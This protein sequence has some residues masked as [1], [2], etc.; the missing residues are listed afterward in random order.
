MCSAISKRHRHFLPAS[1][2]L[3][4]IISA[5]NCFAQPEQNQRLQ[6]DGARAAI[7]FRL[8]DHP[9]ARSVA[10]AGTFNKWNVTPLTRKGADWSVSIAL[11]PGKHLYKFV[12]GSGSDHP[13]VQRS[14]RMNQCDGLVISNICLFG[15]SLPLSVLIQL[16][17]FCTKLQSNND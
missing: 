11:P 14:N 16:K 9:R 6:T 15:R 1:L 7:T 3:V 17:A 4:G 5:A 10:L 8:R 12:T 2:L 13:D